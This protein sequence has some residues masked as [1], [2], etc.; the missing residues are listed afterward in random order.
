MTTGFSLPDVARS[1]MTGERP[2]DGYLGEVLETI[3]AVEPTIRSLLPEPDRADRLHR[4]AAALQR[5][6]PRPAE[7]PPL[8]GVVVGVK[9]IFHVDG[10][11]TA[12]GSRLP[13]EALAGPE[14]E[15]VRRLRRAG[16]LVLGKTV[17]TEFA[18]FAPGPTRNPRNPEH[19]PGGSSSGSAAAVAA[20]LCPLALGTQTIGSIIRP[21]S[22]CGV[23]GF[24][25]SF[26]RVPREG[27][28]PLAPSLDQVGFFTLDASGAAYAAAVLCDG[29]KPEAEPPAPVLGVPVGPY[30]ERSGDVARAHFERALDALRGEGFD[31]RAVAVMADFDE[32]VARHQVLLAAEAAQVH[33]ELFR[34]YGDL[35][36][37][38]TARLVTEGQRISEEELAAA[39]DGQ[40]LF[41]RAIQSLMEENGVDLWLAPSTVGPAPHGLES[42]GDPIMNLPWTQAGLPTISLPCGLDEDGLPLG[43]QLVAGW[44]Q[45]ERLA[46]WA[47]R[48]EAVVTPERLAIPGRGG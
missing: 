28:F 18:Y 41:R 6:Y 47:A 3:E 7:R 13:T 44:Y 42:T 26:R 25:P 38:R 36:H 19:T 2:L 40:A 17:T 16:A 15:S 12:A 48:I 8:F 30:L 43:L 46:A 24:K 37:E 45:D 1:L 27:V 4:E 32:V 33:A 29:W 31:V 11:P 14:A 23:V 39:R 10:L 22:F 20:G 34:R 9:D 21:A 5:L 35:Y